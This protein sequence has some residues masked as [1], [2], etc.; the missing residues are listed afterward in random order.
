MSTTI[1]NTK[2]CKMCGS[3]NNIELEYYHGSE[4]EIV[5]NNENTDKECKECKESVNHYLC[6]D[7]MASIIC[8]CTCKKEQNQEPTRLTFICPCEVIT[9]EKFTYKPCYFD[10]ESF[11]KLNDKYFNKINDEYYAIEGCRGCRFQKRDIQQN[12]YTAMHAAIEYCMFKQINVDS[13]DSADNA[14]SS[15]KFVYQGD[16]LDSDFVEACNRIGIKLGDPIDIN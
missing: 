15:S 3:S 16:S 8:I 9:K 7:C 14:V 6:I 13:A 5:E 2:E 4:L 12:I 1:T 10:I 11:D